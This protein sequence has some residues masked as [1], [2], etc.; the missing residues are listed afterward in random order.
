[1][2]A[3]AG[4]DGGSVTGKNLRNLEEEF[5]LC[6]WTSSA[7]SFKKGYIGYQ[8]PSEDSWRIPLL[9]KLLDQRREMII[10]EEDTSTITGLIDSLCMS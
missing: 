8:I 1:M 9:G 6:P 10:C 7:E 4:S 5:K 3:I 2:A